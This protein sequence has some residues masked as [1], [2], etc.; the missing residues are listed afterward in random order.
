MGT[1]DVRTMAKKTSDGWR[2]DGQKT[3]VL[4]GSAAN[5]IIVSAR[6]DDG[7][8]CPF[9]VP[10]GARGLVSRDYPRLGGGRA[11]NLE[12]SGVELPA[13]AMLGDDAALHRRERHGHAD[14]VAALERGQDRFGRKKRERLAVRRAIEPDFVAHGTRR[15]IYT[16]SV[17]GLGFERAGAGDEEAAEREHA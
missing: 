7:R 9:L 14:H 1:A 2:L 3:A 10:Q 11:C 13:D 16:L 17:R 15:F 8:I 5:Q 12:L 4:D 6:L